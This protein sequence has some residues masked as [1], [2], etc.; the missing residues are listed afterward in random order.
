M[1]A[2]PIGLAEEAEREEAREF[3]PRVA[4]GQQTQQQGYSR[5][6]SF[7]VLPLY[8]TSIVCECLRSEI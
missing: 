5:E 8:S 4:H 3:A 7:V 1:E 6:F 2:R